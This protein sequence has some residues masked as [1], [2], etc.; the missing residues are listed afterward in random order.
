MRGVQAVLEHRLAVRQAIATMRFGR[1]SVVGRTERSLGDNFI[2]EQRP[3]DIG[4]RKAAA[5]SDTFLDHPHAAFRSG[6]FRNAAFTRQPRPAATAG[7]HTHRATARCTIATP[8][9]PPLKPPSLDCS[10]CNE[11]LVSGAP[12]RR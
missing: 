12:H 3:G 8:S 7:A 4:K 1:V 6:W 11:S 5:L 10:P 9:V 2:P